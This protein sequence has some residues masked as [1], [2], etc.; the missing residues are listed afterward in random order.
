MTETWARPLGVSFADALTVRRISDGRARAF[1][2]RHHSYMP[3][4]DRVTVH[5]H[6]AVLD[7]DLVGAITYAMPRRTAG[8]EGVDHRDTVEVARVAV[9]IDMPNLASCFMAA[10]Q[11]TF[12]ARWCAGRG[13]ELLL[14]FVHADYDGSMFAALRGKGWRRVRHAESRPSGNRENRGIE[15]EQKELWTCPVETTDKQTRLRRYATDCS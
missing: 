8:V 4:L 14:T 13:V 9:G 2:E 7:G 10:S 5:N 6:G 11:D 1:Y 12:V 3:Y 15:A